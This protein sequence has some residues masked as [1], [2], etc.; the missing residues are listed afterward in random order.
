MKRRN[1]LKKIVNFLYEVGTARNLVRS[2][3]QV[4]KNA[5]DTIAA[6]SFRVAIIGL[7][8]AELENVSQD[9]VLKMCLLHDLAELR[10]GDANFL[11]QYYRV[12]N[13]EKAI[14]DQWKNIAGG[15]KVISLLKEY[16]TRKSKEARVSKD[17]DILDQIFLQKEYLSQ[18]PYDFKKWHDYKECQLK[19]KSA[20]KI[21]RLV[22]KTGSMDW[23]Y[24]FANSIKKNKK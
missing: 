18:S 10:T 2:H 3:Y 24:D 16:N 9:R 4:I 20:L 14:E 15:K 8:L 6:H 19:T 12:E 11:N 1:N 13:E 5:N 23:V 7:I 17:A 22:L 21:A